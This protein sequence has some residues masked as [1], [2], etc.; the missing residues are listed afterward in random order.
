MSALIDLLGRQ[1]QEV[2][3]RIAADQPRFA[4][5][6]VAA[7]FLDF[8][9]R[10]VM[11][12]FSLEEEILFP[13]LARIPSIAAG[14]LRVMEAEHDSFRDL[15]ARGKEEHARGDD[16]GLGRTAADLAALLQ[17]HIAKE[18]RVL[19]PMALEVLG[20]ERLQVLN[21]AAAL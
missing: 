16:A 19:F 3:A 5:P 14:P 6:E 4:E 13:E 8:L 17:T 18:D 7:R 12:H 11:S 15:L 21:A 1:H 2:L 20:A 10:E 9:Q